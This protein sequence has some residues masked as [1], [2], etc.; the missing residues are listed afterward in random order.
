MSNIELKRLP[1]HDGEPEMNYYDDTCWVSQGPPEFAHRQV[2]SRSF[3]TEAEAAADWNAMIDR[4]IE[5]CRPDAGVDDL[6]RAVTEAIR[7]GK[8]EGHGRGFTCATMLA[9]ALNKFEESRK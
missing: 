9:D 8:N 2:L 1:G 4:I 7:F 5:E 3:P 6:V